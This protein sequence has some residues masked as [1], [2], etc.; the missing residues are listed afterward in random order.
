MLN[1]DVDRTKAP[2]GQ[3]TIWHIVYTDIGCE[4]AEARLLHDR[5]LALKVIDDRM[6]VGSRAALEFLRLRAVE[7]DGAID[8]IARCVF[9]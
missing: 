4:L 6:N 7:P 2:V 1:R 5:A 9:V 8:C 3:N